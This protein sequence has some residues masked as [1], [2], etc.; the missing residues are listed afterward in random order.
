[1]QTV[2]IFPY[3]VEESKLKHINTRLVIF[4]KDGT[5]YTNF[6]VQIHK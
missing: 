6:A 5:E 3:S 2:Y 4:R 1:M